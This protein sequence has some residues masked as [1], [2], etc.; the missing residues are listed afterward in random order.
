MNSIDKILNTGLEDYNVDL[1]YWCDRC[2]ISLRQKIFW[3]AESAIESK[4]LWLHLQWW[5]I[6]S[7]KHHEI[8]FIEALLINNRFSTPEELSGEGRKWN[9]VYT[10]CATIKFERMKCIT[11]HFPLP[12]VSL[13]W[14]FRPYNTSLPITSYPVARSWLVYT[15]LSPAITEQWISLSHIYIERCKSRRTP[16]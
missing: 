3:S 12:P 10:G 16:F 6:S 7:T 5:D 15:V 14:P 13:K 8:A 11:V 4:W 9:T 1:S 2:Y